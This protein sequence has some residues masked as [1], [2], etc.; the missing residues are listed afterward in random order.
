MVLQ[1]HFASPS[2]SW[3]FMHWCIFPLL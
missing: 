3:L 1:I 2:I